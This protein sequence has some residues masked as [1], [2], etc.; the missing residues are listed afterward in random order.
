MN[1]ETPDAEQGAEAVL[2][3]SDT[4][5]AGPSQPAPTSEELLRLAGLDAQTAE[6]LPD[7]EDD[8]PAPVEKTTSVLQQ[9]CVKIIYR[10]DIYIYTILKFL[11]F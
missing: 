7:F 1:W 5:N 6:A 2:D 10:F 11:D 4:E 9:R 3:V 8:P